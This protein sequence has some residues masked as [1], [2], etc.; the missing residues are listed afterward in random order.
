MN[1]DGDMAGYIWM[2]ENK[3]FRALKRDIDGEIDGEIQ[4]EIDVEIDGEIDR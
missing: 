4:G 2:R 1:L 3:I